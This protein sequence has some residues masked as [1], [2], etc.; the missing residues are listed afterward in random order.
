M[1][2]NKNAENPR[3]TWIRPSC[4]QRTV[5]Q[6]CKQHEGQHSWQA[7]TLRF[8]FNHEVNIMACRAQNN[9]S[10][11]FCAHLRAAQKGKQRFSHSNISQDTLNTLYTLMWNSWFNL[12]WLK[13][14]MKHA[15][16]RWMIP[17]VMLRNSSIVTPLFPLTDHTGVV[18]LRGALLGA[19][20]GWIIFSKPLNMLWSSR[21]STDSAHMY[22]PSAK[23]SSSPHLSTCSI[24]RLWSETVAS[25]CSGLHFMISS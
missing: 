9:H 19:W 3:S 2:Q 18:T 6:K 14:G 5:G 11:G 20:N 1:T 8:P 10:E 17:Q 22:A 23:T 13:F 24:K 16:W 21:H 7:H 15:L 12:K 25:G 4:F